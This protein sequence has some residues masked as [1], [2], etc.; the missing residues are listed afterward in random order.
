MNTNKTPRIWIA[1][2]FCAPLDWARAVAWLD[3][4]LKA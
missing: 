4:W 3:R 1:V 2:M